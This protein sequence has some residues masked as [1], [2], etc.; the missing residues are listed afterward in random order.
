MPAIESKKH[1][2]NRVVYE[3][4]KGDLFPCTAKGEIDPTLATIEASC[5]WTADYTNAVRTHS[6]LLIIHIPS[7][8][9]TPL[10]SNPPLME[11]NYCTIQPIA[12]HFCYFLSLGEML[13]LNNWSISEWEERKKCSTVVP[14]S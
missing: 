9:T 4:H 8:Y 2:S 3:L 1:V 5:Q 6:P 13:K 10:P 12:N 11:Y 7:E 14:G